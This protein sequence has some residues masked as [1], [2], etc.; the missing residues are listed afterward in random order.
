MKTPPGNDW[1]LL[2]TEE[3]KRAAISQPISA[4]EENKKNS[5]ASSTCNFKA[6]NR[7]LKPL[8]PAVMMTTQEEKHE[9]SMAADDDHQY[10]EEEA[11]QEVN[12]NAMTKIGIL[13]YVCTNKLYEEE[14]K[15][16]K[17]LKP[18]RSVVITIQGEE[19]KHKNSEAADDD[20]Q[21]LEEDEAKKY[22]DNKSEILPTTR[23]RAILSRNH[24]D[25]WQLKKS[26]KQ[27]K[28]KTVAK[29]KK[30]AKTVVKMKKKLMK[31]ELR[32]VPANDHHPDLP[33]Q[34]RQRI[35]EWQGTSI[36][37][38]IEK[39]LYNTDL[40]EVHDRLTMPFRKIMSDFLSDNEKELLREEGTIKVSVI[41]PKLKEVTLILRQW[42][43]T[44]PSG[45]TSSCYVL[46]TKWKDVV[47][48]NHLK[49]HQRLQVWSFRVEEKIHMALVVLG[50]E[51]RNNQVR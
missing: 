21:Y 27:K 43:M 7:V 3:E 26:K 39:T 40:S 17:A 34:F 32:Q 23:K 25:D 48:N 31:F 6:H 12:L 15:A 37:L 41:D 46:R 28:A 36:T 4:A 38:V 14:K 22:V 44:K 5:T 19:E 29:I 2:L 18:S 11:D 35:N 16:R 24:D 49:K 9:N 8:V 47:H 33:L 10:L 1:R 42:D 50:M 51:A 30:K 45:K 20:D 13:A